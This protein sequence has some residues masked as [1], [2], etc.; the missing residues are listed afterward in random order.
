MMGRKQWK[1]SG[2][3][4]PKLK[5]NMSLQIVKVPLGAEQKE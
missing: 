5:N 4:F 1:N 3:D 2:Q